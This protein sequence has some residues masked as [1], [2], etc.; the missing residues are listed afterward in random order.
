MF[1]REQ[2]N[3]KIGVVAETSEPAQILR[4]VVDKDQKLDPRAPEAVEN[5]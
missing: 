1:C 5:R 3:S 4:A 2:T